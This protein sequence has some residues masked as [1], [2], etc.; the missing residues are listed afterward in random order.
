MV[1]IVKRVCDLRTTDGWMYNSGKGSP[2][3]PVNN[4]GSQI[5]G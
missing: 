1:R 5:H 4:R 2:K 3:D